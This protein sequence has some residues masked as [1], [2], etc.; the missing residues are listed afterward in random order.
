MHDDGEAASERY[1]GLFEATSFCDLERPG[2]QRE[3]LL[4]A[5]QN[6]VG[7]FVEQLAHGA[8]ALLGDPA[9]PV[10]LAGLVA[11]RN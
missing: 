3:A 8:V 11:S 5:R 1:P 4:R 2:F 10:D 6:R 9:R 7:R